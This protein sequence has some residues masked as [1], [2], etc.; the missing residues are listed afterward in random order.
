LRLILVVPLPDPGA[1]PQAENIAPR[2]SIPAIFRQILTASGLI[3]AFWNNH[4]R[5]FPDGPQ[6]S[7]GK[8]GNQGQQRSQ[9]KNFPSWFA[10]FE[11]YFTW[12]ATFCHFL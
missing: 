10:T 9:V 6:R 8:P 3:A 5:P 4:R 1:Q 12:L 2:P 7:P 11:I